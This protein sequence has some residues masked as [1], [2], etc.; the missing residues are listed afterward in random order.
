MPEIVVMVQWYLRAVSI[1][2]IDGWLGLYGSWVHTQEDQSSP[3]FIMNY[4]EGIRTQIFPIDTPTI[5]SL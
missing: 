2:I 3:L 5:K 1:D 4:L